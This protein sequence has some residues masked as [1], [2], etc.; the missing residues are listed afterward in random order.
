[1]K[2]FL[3]NLSIFLLIATSP[4]CDTD[5]CKD[6]EYQPL[7]TVV[8]DHI[9]YF[10]GQVAKFKTSNGD[11]FSA[12][13]ERASEILRPDAPLICQDYL[14]VA[15]KINGELFAEFIERGSVEKDSILQLS[16]FTLRTNQASGAQIAVSDKGAMQ[17]VAANSISIQ[18]PSIDIDGKTYEQVLEI[19]FAPG[20]IPS[21]TDLTQLFYNKKDGIIQ[22]TTHSGVTVTRAN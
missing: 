12:I 13:T 9:P 14:Y 21:D 17:S 7:N 8:A 22:Y 1:M 3:L 6:R 2:I 4:G 5:E 11:S 18:H 10:S 19:N 16:I 15:L 20:D